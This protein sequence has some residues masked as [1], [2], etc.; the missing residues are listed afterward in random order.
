MIY[1]YS[2]P[3]AGVHLADDVGER[4]LIDG[5]RYELPE[6]DADVQRLASLGF[7]TACDQAI[8]S[9]EKKGAKRGG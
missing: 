7:L 4:V 5:Q 1:E 3:V 6:A 8:E 9:I 2:G